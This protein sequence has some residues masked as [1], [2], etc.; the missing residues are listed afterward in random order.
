MTVGTLVW[1]T[2]PKLIN[3]GWS[4]TMFRFTRFGEVANDE[5]AHGVMTKPIA[6]AEYSKTAEPWLVLLELPA[7]RQHLKSHL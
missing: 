7:L 6:R 1:F 5:E 4:I 2:D 3:D